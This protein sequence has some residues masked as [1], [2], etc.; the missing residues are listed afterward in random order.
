VFDQYRD[1]LLKIGARFDYTAD[2]HHFAFFP[3][4]FPVDVRHNSKINREQLA[5][6][7]AKKLGGAP[8]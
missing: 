2:I 8:A 4:L 6:W 5:V 1:E 3:G 7:A